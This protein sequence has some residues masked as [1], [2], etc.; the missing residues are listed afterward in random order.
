MTNLS[1][2]LED[3]GEQ[4]TGVRREGGR[5]LWTGPVFSVDNRLVL[6]AALTKTTFVPQWQ[7]THKVLSLKL[8]A[9]SPVFLPPWLIVRD[10][11]FVESLALSRMENTA[12]R[13]GTPAMVAPSVVYVLRA[14]SPVCT[15]SIFLFPSKVTFFDKS[16]TNSKM[17]ILKVSITIQ[18]FLKN[19]EA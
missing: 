14:I 4:D 13:P 2:G 6:E 1:K 12:P 16:I 9:F 19:Y 8:L 3:H 17:V 10:V 18:M 15:P 11:V 7:F 5:K